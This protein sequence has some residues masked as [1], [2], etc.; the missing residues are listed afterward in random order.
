L[1][2]RQYL[3]K[4]ATLY[5]PHC[6]V[7]TPVVNGSLE[8]PSHTIPLYCSKC[9]NQISRLIYNPDTHALDLDM[10][11]YKKEGSSR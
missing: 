7:E 1:S 4:G 11:Y 3:P 6:K 8:H 10:A 9:K 2:D 5:C